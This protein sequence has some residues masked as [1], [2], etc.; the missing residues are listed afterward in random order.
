MRTP[1]STGR[2]VGRLGNIYSSTKILMSQNWTD[3]EWISGPRMDFYTRHV[4]GS[5]IN[6]PC[7]I[8]IYPLRKDKW[9]LEFRQIDSYETPQASYRY[10]K[11]LLSQHCLCTRNCYDSVLHT[12]NSLSVDSS[13]E[14]VTVHTQLG[15]EDVLNKQKYLSKSHRIFLRAK[16][17]ETDCEFNFYASVLTP[18]A[19]PIT[20]GTGAYA[21]VQRRRE[22]EKERKK[23]S[24]LNKLFSQFLVRPLWKLD[25]YSFLRTFWNMYIFNLH[26]CLPC[27]VCF[28]SPYLW[29]KY[30]HADLVNIISNFSLQ[31]FALQLY[32]LLITY[33]F[34]LWS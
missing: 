34:I 10:K 14:T 4:R 1:W 3:R 6:V 8:I 11:G 33:L 2:P 29:P 5:A 15:A 7:L 30:V 21:I 16:A 31:T 18:P 32:D 19:V 28:I 22:K 9:C 24:L 23:K 26:V 27:L 20:T 13:G 12:H 25:H 17:Y